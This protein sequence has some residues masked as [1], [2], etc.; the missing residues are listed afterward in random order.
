[1]KL[2]NVERLPA[3]TNECHASTIVYHEGHR[4][5]AWFGGYQEGM[6]CDIWARV[7]EG[8]AVPVVF[9]THR[10]MHPS[11]MWN[12]ILFTVD[13]HLLMFYKEGKFCDSWQT[14]L[15]ECY[16]KDGELKVQ[17]P[18]VIPA[19]FNGP[20]KTKPFQEG[21]MLICGSS[22]ETRDDW[23]SY[24]EVYNYSKEGL[25]IA[26]RS[27]P[28]KNKP[29]KAKIKGIIQPAIWKEDDI[30]HMLIRSSSESSFIYHSKSL[31]NNPLYWEQATPTNINNPN[32]SIDVLQYSNGKLYIAYNPGSTERTPLVIAEFELS[33]KYKLPFLNIKKSVEIDLEEGWADLHDNRPRTKELSYPYM[34]ENAGTIEVSYTF[35]RKEIRLA[36]IEV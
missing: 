18:A 24:V 11:S 31:P 27:N 16:I 13:G 7:D 36:V 15:A 23:S 3:E 14:F 30:Y 28:I 10:Y 32:S 1:M 35:C 34:L 2:L 4:I 6:A 19:G 21:T 5:I 29:N 8:K 33:Y 22:V 20:V 17:K 26:G 12:P 25:G 9:S